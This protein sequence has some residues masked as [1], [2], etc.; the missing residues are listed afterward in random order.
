MSHSPIASCNGI[1][2]D[3]C[4][5][6]AR[7]IIKTGETVRATAIRFELSKSTV[8]KDVA[9]KLRHVNPALYASVREVLERN[10]SERHLRGGDATRLMYMTRKER[11]N[12]NN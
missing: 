8:H 5:L 6:L 11:K 12:V 4:E 2:Q 9:E 10:K 7:H 3:R 1:S